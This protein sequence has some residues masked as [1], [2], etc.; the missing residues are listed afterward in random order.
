MSDDSL[1]HRLTHQV[2]GVPEHRE[3]RPHTD[4]K[5]AHSRHAHNQRVHD[6]PARSHH[7]GHDRPP[8]ILVAWQR[9]IAALFGQT[10]P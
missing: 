1:L 8:R 4:D 2:P 10:L 6:Q 5:H 3:N 7:H 9:R